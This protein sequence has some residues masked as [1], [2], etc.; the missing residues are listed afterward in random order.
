MKLQYHGQ[1][2]E[3]LATTPRF[4]EENAKILSKFEEDFGCALPAALREWYCIEN[5]QS[6]LRRITPNQYPIELH[7]VIKIHEHVLGN[8][9]LGSYLFFLIEN[10]WVCHWAV[11]TSVGD[12]PPML[13]R[14][15]EPNE[16]WYVDTPTFSDWLFCTAWDHLIV[17][18]N[19]G[20]IVDFDSDDKL[21]SYLTECDAIF[22]ETFRC[23]QYF[24]AKRFARVIHRGVK[25]LIICNPPSGSN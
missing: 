5:W 24:R 12:N 3:L 16:P 23:N 25:Q 22:L 13:M 2:F 9:E 1:F 21:S 19:M 15:F 17:N 20:T 10:Q 7:D 4:S 14:Y 8:S 6:I 18:E 11:H